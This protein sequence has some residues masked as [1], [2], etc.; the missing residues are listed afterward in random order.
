MKIPPDPNVLLAQVT[1]DAWARSPELGWALSHLSGDCQVSYDPRVGTACIGRRGRRYRLRLDPSFLR[2]ELHCEDDLLFLLLHEVGHRLRGD[3]H[4]D[5]GRD[6]WER[7]LANVV[8]DIQINAALW[9]EHFPAGVPLLERLYARPGLET[10]L[11]PPSL[12]LLR[13]AAG[14][15]KGHLRRFMSPGDIDGE[16]RGELEQVAAFALKTDL[17]GDTDLG[18]RLGEWY[19][20]AWLDDDT[21]ESLRLRLRKLLRSEASGCFSPTLLGDH[22]GR[23]GGPSWPSGPWG[24]V[25]GREG[26]AGGEAEEDAVEVANTRRGLA[27]LRLAILAALSLE[28][29]G[30][31][32]DPSTQRPDVVPSVDRRAA[33][34]LSQGVCPIFFRSPALDAKREELRV[35]VYVDVS[36]STGSAQPL[37]Y[38]LLSQLS[39]VLQPPVHLFSNEVSDIS[40]AELA[41]GRRRTTWGTDFDCLLEHALEAGYQ[42][43]LVVTDGYASFKAEVAERVRKRGL[44]VFLLYTAPPGY[45]PLE[46]LAQASWTLP[47]SA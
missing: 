9:R 8:A 42:R 16:A 19:A 18:F 1:R 2:E 41:K 15:G 10:L 23:E 24:K 47:G 21:Q 38:G 12:L 17:G 27:E 43:I 3:L 22:R 4:R 39:Q 40:L 7:T 44:R 6:P 25:F 30:S 28:E 32:Y 26:G 31:G 37:I 5:V 45:S 35:R 11:L 36:G 29:I 13:F 33:L 34:L 20:D 14:A 46:E